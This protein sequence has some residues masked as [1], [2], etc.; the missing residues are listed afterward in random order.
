MVT[1]TLLSQILKYFAKFIAEQH[2][3][4]NEKLVSFDATFDLALEVVSRRLKMDDTLQERTNL[5][6]QS[7]I[8]LLHTHVCLDA[9]FFAFHGQYYQQ[10]LGTAMGSSVSVTIANIV[11]DRLRNM[12][13]QRSVQ[14]HTS[15]NDTWMKRVQL[16]QRNAYPSFMTILTLS[17]LTSSSQQRRKKMEFYDSL[18]SS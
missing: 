2:I 14:L 12:L 15:G 17:I 13:Y 5:I 8:S 16:F 3:Q 11:M 7:I 10:I 18:T 9:T 4:D 6:M 1:L